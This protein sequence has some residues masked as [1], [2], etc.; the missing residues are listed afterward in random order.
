G[1][2][3]PHLYAIPSDDAATY[4]L[5][6]RGETIG[7]FQIESRAQI[8]SLL[9]TRPERLYDIAVQVALIRPGPIQARFVRPYTERRRG[10]EPVTYPDPRLRPI[11]E[12]TQGIPI[13]QEQAM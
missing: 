12:R 8:V 6:S 9:H 5:I 3:R 11:L 1:G 10:R 4:D 7:M 2:E 13:F